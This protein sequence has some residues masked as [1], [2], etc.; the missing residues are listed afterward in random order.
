MQKIRDSVCANNTLGMKADREYEAGTFYLFSPVTLRIRE[1]YRECI[2]SLDN[3][4][5]KGKETEI[6]ISLP[7]QILFTSKK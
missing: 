5:K 4:R 1:R 2:D 3:E 6:Q 7:L